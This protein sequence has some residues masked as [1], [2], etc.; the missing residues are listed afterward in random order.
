MDPTPD[1]EDQAEYRAATP[2]EHPE[3]VP[4][5]WP[6]TIGILGVCAMFTLLLLVLIIRLT[7]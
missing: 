2:H 1:T 3:G 5:G 6:G 7:N 4:L